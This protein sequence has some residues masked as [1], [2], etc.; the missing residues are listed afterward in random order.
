MTTLIG[1]KLF[2]YFWRLRF[3]WQVFGKLVFWVIRWRSVETRISLRFYPKLW[4]PTQYTTKNWCQV[5]I[6]LHLRETTPVVS[7]HS[8]RRRRPENFSVCSLIKAGISN[9]VFRHAT[10][11]FRQN[12]HCWF[13][14]SY[15]SHSVPVT[16]YGTVTYGWRYIKSLKNE[17]ERKTF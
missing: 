8:G 9:P 10:R 1:G 16:S 14:L 6:L 15:L 13:C 11:F 4:T 17:Y 2:D 3:D 5:Q 12:S 7:Q